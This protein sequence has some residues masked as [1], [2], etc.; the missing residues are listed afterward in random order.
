M[1]RVGVLAHDGIA[2]FELGVAAE[3]FAL[4]RPELGAAWSYSFALCAERPGP[5]D[6][7][8]GFGLVAPHGLDELAAA[9]TLVVPGSPDVHGEPSARVVGA[10]RSAYERGARVVS[11]CSGAFTLAGA[12]LLDGR[13]ATTHWR[14]AELLAGRYPRVHVDRDVLYVDEGDILTS[15]GTA[16]GID[17]CIHLV[18][19]DHGAAVANA[20]ARR[21]VVA[22]HRD[23]GQAQFVDAPVGREPADDPVARVMEWALGRLDAP[24]SVAE[25]ATRA[26]LSPR[27]FARRF[28]A[29][30]GTSPSGWLIAQRVRASVP[31]LESS[32]EPVEEVGRLVGFPTPAAYRRHFRRELG[33]PPAAYRRTFRTRAA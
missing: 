13:R 20:V 17:L 27:Q 7:L 19:R 33:V 11:F 28:R 29:A 16:A 14:Y 9:D 1:H 3:V 22:P 15:A 18:R 10:L 30:T 6:A 32:D 31:L 25:M 2:P 21:M 12:G 5:L 8:G 24:P 26:H 4:P 23:G